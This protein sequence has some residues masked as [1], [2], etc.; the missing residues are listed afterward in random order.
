MFGKA[1]YA[2]AVEV[3]ASAG[4]GAFL[5]SPIRGIPKGRGFIRRAGDE[6]DR[7]GA[8]AFP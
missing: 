5:P 1:L 4:V 3:F 8:Q 6:G 7:M 2:L